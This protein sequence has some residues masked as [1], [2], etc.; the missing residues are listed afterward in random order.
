MKLDLE[1]NVTLYLSPL[2]GNF[3]DFE[4]SACGIVSGTGLTLV[5][6]SHIHVF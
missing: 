5:F 3:L 4:C 2:F 6:S 1:E